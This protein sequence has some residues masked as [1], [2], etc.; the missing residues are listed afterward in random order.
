MISTKLTLVTPRGSY[1]LDVWIPQGRREQERGLQG[2]EAELTVNRGML[3]LPEQL[4]DE[5]QDA[6][7]KIA[8]WLA[9]VR[10]PLAILWFRSNGTL[11]HVHTVQPGDTSSFVEPGV[12]VLEVRADVV[13]RLGIV[14]ELTR[15]SW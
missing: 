13:E 14:P 6:P 8:M 4:S 10:V 15:A 9:S 7:N 11:G 1:T 5:D 2:F 3:F 12:A